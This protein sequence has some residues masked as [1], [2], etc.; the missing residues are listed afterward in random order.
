MDVPLPESAPTPR[1]H[2]RSTAQKTRRLTV[3]HDERVPLRIRT[4]RPPR[5]VRPH[6]EQARVHA[7]RQLLPG[8]PADVLRY[9]SLAPVRRSVVLRVQHIRPGPNVDGHH[10]PAPRAATRVCAGE[11]R[12][13]RRVAGKHPE[14]AGGRAVFLSAEDNVVRVPLP[15]THD[16]CR[17][18]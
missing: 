15:R 13:A 10:R 16:E 17:L 8:R 11:L 3:H 5:H 18:G 14:E 9:R 12:P 2:I 6:P 1:L 4:P 7:R